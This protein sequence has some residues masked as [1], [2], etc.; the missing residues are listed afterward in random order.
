MASWLGRR[1]DVE[2]Y[3]HDEIADAFGKSLSF[4]KTQVLRGT[5]KLREL[6]GTTKEQNA[7]A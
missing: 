4:S 5:H 2:G 3:K 6:L 7:Y 1:F